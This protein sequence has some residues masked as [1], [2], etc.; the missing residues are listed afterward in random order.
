VPRAEEELLR[1][2]LRGFGPATVQDYVAWT[3]MTFG[4]AKGIWSRVSHELVPVDVNGSPAWILSNDLPVL[5]SSVASGPSVRLLPNFDSFTL[6]HMNRG[7]L[8]E[9]SQHPKIYR[10]Q[11]WVS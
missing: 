4:D 5:A 2:Y 10:P 9:A 11:G 6:G 8:V 3:R 7:H 1:L